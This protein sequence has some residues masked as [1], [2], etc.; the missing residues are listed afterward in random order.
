MKSRMSQRLA[1]LDSTIAAMD[2]AAERSSRVIPGAGS[3]EILV[4]AMIRGQSD[5]SAGL[6]AP[7]RQTSSVGN[8]TVLEAVDQHPVAVLHAVEQV[9]QRRL[10]GAAKLVHQRP[11]VVAQRQLPSS[12]IPGAGTSP[13]LAGRGQCSCGC[14]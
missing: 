2:R 11:A 14:A 4:I 6:P 8:L 1:A 9:V 12:L 7:A 10:G 3:D 5:H 13:L